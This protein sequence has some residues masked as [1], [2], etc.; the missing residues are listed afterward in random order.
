MNNNVSYIHRHTH[1]KLDI[2][3]LVILEGQIL[4]NYK[5]L[6]VGRYFNLANWWNMSLS[7]HIMNEIGQFILA[8]GEKVTKFAKMKLLHNYQLLW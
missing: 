6:M 5:F 3:Q 1:I 2:V 8:N 4:A 7:M